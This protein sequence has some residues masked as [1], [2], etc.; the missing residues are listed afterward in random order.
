MKDITD[1]YW[2]DAEKLK[3]FADLIY[4]MEY[5]CE[6][7]SVDIDMTKVDHFYEFSFVEL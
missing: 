6:C 4:A 5:C 1:T 3:Y 2:T 7:D